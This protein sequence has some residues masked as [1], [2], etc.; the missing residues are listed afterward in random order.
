[1]NRSLRSSVGVGPNSPA[2]KP[3]PP[4]PLPPPPPSQH[5]PKQCF[6]GNSAREFSTSQLPPL[7]NALYEEEVIRS[8]PTISH[9]P[10]CRPS[11]FP[12]GPGRRPRCKSTKSD[13]MITVTVASSF[14]QVFVV[15]NFPEKRIRVRVALVIHVPTCLSEGSST[16]IT[17][18]DTFLVHPSHLCKYHE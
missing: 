4:P 16:H 18:L 5:Q 2:R 17:P 14:F 9:F 10:K 1:M 15:L 13:R 11:I 6:R 7:A 3:K 8:S 12:Y